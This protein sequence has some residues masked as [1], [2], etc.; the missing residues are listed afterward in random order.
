MILTG[1]TASAD[2]S[3]H[4]DFSAVTFKEENATRVTV[5][6]SLFTHSPA[7]A[8]LNYR[9]SVGLLTQSAARDLTIAEE[10]VAFCTLPN[11][12]I[13]H[14]EGGVADANVNVSAT[15]GG[16]RVDFS[17]KLPLASIDRTS[18][19]GT[20]S[21]TVAGEFCNY[22]FKRCST[23]FT[24]RVTA[25]IGTYEKTRPVTLSLENLDV[26]TSLELTLEEVSRTLTAAASCEATLTLDTYWGE[27]LLGSDTRSFTVTVPACE[28]TRPVITAI[29]I[30]PVSLPSFSGLYVQGKTPVSVSVTGEA[31]YGAQILRCEAE[32]E[33]K[34]YVNATSLDAPLSAGELPV[35]LRVIDTRG[36]SREETRTL[37][38]LPYAAP[39]LLPPDG[40]TQPSAARADGGTSLFAA[41]A[42]SIS[43]IAVNGEAKNGCKL[44]C[45]FRATTESAFGDWITLAESETFVGNVAG[46]SLSRVQS[47]AVEL[48]CVDRVGERT[49]LTL[50]VSTEEVSFHLRAGGMGAAFGKYAE[51]E[52]VLEIAPDWTL[53]LHGNLDDS[54]TIADTTAYALGDHAPFC[55]VRLVGGSRV[56]AELRLPVEGSA[57]Q[58]LAEA[59]LDERALPSRCVYALCPCTDGAIANVSLDTDGTLTLLSLWGEGGAH[60]LCVNV[61]Y[62]AR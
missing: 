60:T 41:L 20:V 6:L 54:V 5:K 53:R 45:R 30:S 29:Q 4:V 59:F 23:A 37:S 11:L 26:S 32:L 27:Q 44:Q 7:R 46:V 39:R 18:R 19:I 58:T 3:Y 40:Y 56:R 35:T 21:N 62:D 34:T 38:V 9:A 42:A 24:H 2:V 10:P 33:G 28:E 8:T 57:P 47:Y 52:R 15:F 49:G 55:R 50:Y 48:S 22:T 61:E 12:L 25:R 43:P 1:T 51:E 16:K 31:R 17:C 13:F 36:F 14:N